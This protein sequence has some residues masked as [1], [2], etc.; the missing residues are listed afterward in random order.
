ML[1]IA[2]L[3]VKAVEQYKEKMT[4]ICLECPRYPRNC[5]PRR[6]PNYTSVKLPACSSKATLFGIIRA[7]T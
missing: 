4:R 7:Y 1:D 2:E 3:T 5:P 6:C